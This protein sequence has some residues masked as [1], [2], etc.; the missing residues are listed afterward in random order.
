MTKEKICGI[1]C[2]ENKVN[3]KKY[4]GQSIDIY[5]RW[6]KHLQNANRGINTILYNAIRKYGKDMSDID[7]II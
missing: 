4:I 7:K 6:K 5:N 1:Y 2:I 3:G